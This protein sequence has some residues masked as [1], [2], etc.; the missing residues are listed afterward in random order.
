MH[1]HDRGQRDASMERQAYD[2]A[3]Q[4]FL[5][6]IRTQGEFAK[7]VLAEGTVRFGDL[8]Q[9]KRAG[10]VDLERT[11]VDQMV[12]LSSRRLAADSIVTA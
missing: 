9:R 8:L 3:M 5:S 10:H 11:R 6:S 1:P 2:F 7:I 4:H 12:E